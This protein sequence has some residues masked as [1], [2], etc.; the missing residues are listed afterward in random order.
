MCRC[1]K[2]QAQLEEGV[3][4][5]NCKLR[6]ILRFLSY[7]FQFS[8]SQSAGF[9]KIHKGFFYRNP[10]WAALCQMQLI[11]GPPKGESMLI[12]G[13]RVSKL[14]RQ[15]QVESSCTQ[16]YPVLSAQAKHAC[17]SNSNSGSGLQGEQYLLPWA[18]KPTKSVKKAK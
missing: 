6:L 10:R 12:Q 11:Q 14:T 8:P 9:H 16:Y 15:A 18:L 2:G 3:L 13:L 5:T 1:L 17:T 4:G 7:R